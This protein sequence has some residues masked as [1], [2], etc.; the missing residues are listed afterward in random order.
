MV[1]LFKLINGVRYR[2]FLRKNSLNDYTESFRL[3]IMDS[4]M[5]TRLQDIWI[6]KK[7]AM[8]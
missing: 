4:V 7:S 6:C 8:G 2:K 3:E 1:K 5:M